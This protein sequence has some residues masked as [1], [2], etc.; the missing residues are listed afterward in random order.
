VV[1]SAVKTMLAGHPPAE[2]R[3]FVAVT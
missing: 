2:S 1:N 3:S